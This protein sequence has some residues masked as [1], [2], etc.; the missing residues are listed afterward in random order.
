MARTVR[1][2]A[3]VTR[4]ARSRL[5]PATKRMLEQGLHLG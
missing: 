4:S 3:L 2:A 1:D 5:A